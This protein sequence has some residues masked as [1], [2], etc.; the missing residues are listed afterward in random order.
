MS[1]D[2]GINPSDITRSGL[3]TYRA[4]PPDAGK[5][6]EVTVTNTGNDRTSRQFNLHINPFVVHHEIIDEGQVLPSLSTILPED[7]DENSPDSVSKYEILESSPL[8]IQTNE[9]TALFEEILDSL[10]EETG[11]FSRSLACDVVTGDPSQFIHFGFFWSF[12]NST[13]VTTGIGDVMIHNAE[14]CNQRPTFDSEYD[15][16]ISVGDTIPSLADTVSNPDHPSDP[17]SRYSIRDGDS[18]PSLPDYIVESLNPDT[19]EFAAPFLC[20]SIGSDDRREFSF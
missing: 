6:C 9:Q 8:T 20:D 18:E 3:F 10:D 12:E 13:G 2:C 17:I 15:A 19:G 1:N 16:D 11:D 4:S 14:N 5:T 7:P